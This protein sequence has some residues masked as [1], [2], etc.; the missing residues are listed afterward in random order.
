MEGFSVIEVNKRVKM[1]F[2]GSGC[3]GNGCLF[4]L[5]SKLI[6]TVVKMFVRIE[7]FK[8]IAKVKPAA[9]TISASLNASV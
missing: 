8:L 9:F 5:Y 2:N 4:F 3:S 1:C 6:I 7:R